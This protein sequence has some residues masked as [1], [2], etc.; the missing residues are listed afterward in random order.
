MEAERQAD[1]EYLLP[2]IYDL[3][4]ETNYDELPPIL[5]AGYGA[6]GSALAY[7]NDKGGFA[8]NNNVLGILAI[9]NRLWSSYQTESPAVSRDSSIRSLLDI[10]D[11]IPSFPPKTLKRAESLPSANLPVLY[12][13]SGKA[14][15]HPLLDY[16]YGKNPYQVIFYT[17]RLASGPIAIAIIEGT[18]PL[19]YQDFPLT[20]PVY[21]FALPGLKDTANFISDTAGIIGNFA[22]LLLEQSIQ[23]E[24]ES[25]DFFQPV[26]DI[27]PRSPISGSLYVKN[28]VMT[29]LEL[30]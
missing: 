28:R 10:V 19:D 25:D 3:L 26:K 5:L 16:G 18:S 6:G 15:K 4:G 23:A 11:Y 8:S 21:S 2:R 14:L 27:P 9:E 22:S 17:E 20:H 1:I 29:W 24:P 13:I 12:L 7:L 30:K